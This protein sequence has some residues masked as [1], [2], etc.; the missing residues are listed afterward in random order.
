M[1]TLYVFGPRVEHSWNTT[2][3]IKFYIVAGLGGWLF[4]LIFARDGLLVGASAGVF[5]VTLAYAM[6]W[7]DDEVFLLGVLPIKVK[8]MAALLIGFNLIHGLTPS[9]QGSGTAY[10][11]HLGGV[12]AAWLY[13]RS[14]GTGASIDRLKQRVS[15]V[16]DLPDETPRAVPR[17][18]PRSREQQRGASGGGID[19]IVA[20]SNAALTQRPSADPAPASARA[21]PPRTGDLDAVLDKISRSGIDSLTSSERRLLEQMSRELRGKE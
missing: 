14:A 11:A 2:E 18:M 3:F 1:Y 4:H 6:Q 15:A 16:P 5:G 17:S 7:P 9:G 21:E 8:W 12:A 20:R 10:M 19:E 13:L